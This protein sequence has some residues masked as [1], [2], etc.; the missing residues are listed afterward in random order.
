MDDDP[1]RCCELG[2]VA[3]LIRENQEKVIA[4]GDSLDYNLMSFNQREVTTVLKVLLEFRLEVIYQ[5]PI[6]I[7]LLLDKTVTMY[8]HK[9]G[10]GSITIAPPIDKVLN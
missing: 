9:K 6:G 8:S 1:D 10:K 5:Q 3:T 7:R 2:M 4:H